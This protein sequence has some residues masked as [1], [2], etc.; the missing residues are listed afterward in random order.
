MSRV[1]ALIERFP[2]YGYRRIAAVLGENRKPIQRILQ[3]KGWQVRSRPRGHRPRARAMSSVARWPDQ[4]WA[5]DL[6]M[7]WCGRDRWCHLALVI[8]C[9]SRQLMGWRLSARGHAKTAEAALEDALI[10][11]FGYLGRVSAPLVLRSD[12]GFVFTSRTYTATVRAY[13]LTQETIA[14]KSS[15]YQALPA[16]KIAE[17]IPRRFTGSPCTFIGH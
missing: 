16:V 2:T 9:G 12:N 4:R 11:R 15:R 5:T 17:V 1:K 14:S 7:V 13:G 8:D 10:N 6:A 3:R